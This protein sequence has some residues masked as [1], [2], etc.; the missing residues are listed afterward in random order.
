MPSSDREDPDRC[1]VGFAT[2]RHPAKADGF[3]RPPF[4][5]PMLVDQMRDSSPL[6]CGRHH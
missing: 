6:A 1:H 4:A 5:H 2:D 3:T